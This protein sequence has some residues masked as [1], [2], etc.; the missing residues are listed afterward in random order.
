MSKK[1]QKLHIYTHDVF[2][3]GLKLVWLA[4]SLSGRFVHTDL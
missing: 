4:L 3:L 1:V 2:K